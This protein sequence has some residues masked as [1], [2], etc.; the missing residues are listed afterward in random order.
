MDRF[1]VWSQMVFWLNWLITFLA[2]KF[3]SS[4]NRLFMYSQISFLAKYGI[5]CIANKSISSMNRILV[6]SQVILRKLKMAYHISCK[7]IYF[8]N[9]QILCVFRYLLVKCGITT[10]GAQNIPSVDRICVCSLVTWGK[11]SCTD[12]QW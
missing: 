4:M 6:S 10:I 7:Q 11:I 12:L 9:E 1:F 3:I 8:L 2:S 5:T